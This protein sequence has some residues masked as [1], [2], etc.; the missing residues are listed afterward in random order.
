M[1]QQIAHV[2][3]EQER[4]EDVEFDANISFAKMM[5]SEPVL[6]GLHKNGFINP[7]PIQRR[8]IPLGRGGLGK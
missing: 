7:S 2:W 1:D 3:E 6:L 8:A 4:T 5:L